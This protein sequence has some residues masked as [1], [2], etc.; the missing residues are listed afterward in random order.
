MWV[1][2]PITAKEVKDNM[3]EFKA[4]AFDGCIGS[5][6]V[7]HIIMEK[8]LRTLEKSEYWTKGFTYN[9]SLSACCES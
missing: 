6:D 7:T 9:K 3:S 4:A 2:R 1:K 5:A 8:L